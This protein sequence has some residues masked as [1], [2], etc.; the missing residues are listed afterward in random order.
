M[1][2]EPK[3]SGWYYLSPAGWVGPFKNRW[4]AI[5]T[6]APYGFKYARYFGGQ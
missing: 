3:V 1:I 5:D 4:D 2:E 6:G